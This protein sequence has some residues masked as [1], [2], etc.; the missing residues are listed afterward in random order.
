[1]SEVPRVPLAAAPPARLTLMEWSGWLAAVGAVT[2]GLV[3]LRDVLG[4]VHVT[5]A[6]L[7]LVQFAS[8]RGGRPLG[9]AVAGLAFLCFDYFL[10]PPYHT[11]RLGRPLDWL[12]LS[13]FLITSFVSAQLL[14]R[15]RSEAA[16]ARQRL[17][18]VERLAGEAERAR[19]L[20][21][22]H[23]AKDAILASVSHDLRTPLTSIRALAHEL[24]DG[25]DERAITIAEE[26]DRLERFVADTL[27]LSRI[28]GR[29]IV[30][31]VQPNEAEDLVGA[32][33][34]RIAGRL[35]GREL[36]IDIR[37]SDTLL[38]GRFDFAQT[39]RA[40]VNLLENAVKYSPAG[41][42]IDLLVR[43]EAG[44]LVFSVADRGPGVP[45]AERDRI[46][47]PFYR[48]AG[49]PPDVT[50]LGL[51]LSLARGL[52]MAQEASV[53]YVPREGGGSVF[54]IRV[55]AID[56]TDNAQIRADASR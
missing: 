39:L 51:G 4:E 37:P 42:A 26:A 18:E 1:V 49:S 21:E 38:F 52:M 43:S 19:T 36:R 34:Q 5:L 6:Y 13:A 55:P 14:N 24:A 22:A 30:L 20:Q 17:A 28:A 23:R 12:V 3:A 40:L 7:L 50:G 15:A 53:V 8:A 27:D 48:P 44:V 41:S 47:E 33:A 9:F 35:E 56:V 32:A 16:L 54:E 29:M 2:A 46:F 31:D 45:E 25:G 10:L 11:L